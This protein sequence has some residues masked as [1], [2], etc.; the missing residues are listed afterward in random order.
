MKIKKVAI[1][2][3][4][5]YKLEKEGINKLDSIYIAY[6][7]H[8][9]VLDQIQ[10]EFNFLFPHVKIYSQDHPAAVPHHLDI[11]IIPVL[12]NPSRNDILTTKIDTFSWKELNPNYLILYDLN[13]RLIDILLPNKL[14]CYLFK[15]RSISLLL[16]L[17]NRMNKF[18]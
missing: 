5:K 13:A 9:W 3:Y 1:M 14:R 2:I 15:R 12:D 10:D 18:L 7:K 16:K 17:L 11:V 4:L 6:D 8:D